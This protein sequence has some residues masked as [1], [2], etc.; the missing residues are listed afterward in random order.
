LSYLFLLW[1]QKEYELWP[2]KELQ[3]LVTSF[4]KVTIF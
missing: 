3:I 1:E 2:T 4:F